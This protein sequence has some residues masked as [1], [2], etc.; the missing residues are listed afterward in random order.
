MA[1][2]VAVEAMAQ[3][4]HGVPAVDDGELAELEHLGVGGVAVAVVGGRQRAVAGQRH[5]GRPVRPRLGGFVSAAQD[6]GAGVE[7]QP[8]RRQAGALQGPGGDA[9]ED[10]MAL[11]EEGVEGPAEAVVVERV[12]GAVGEEGG[13]PGLVGPGG[14]VDEGGGLA[15]TT[16]LSAPPPRQVKATMGVLPVG[17]SGARLEKSRCGRAVQLYLTGAVN[18]P[19][20][21]RNGKNAAG[22]TRPSV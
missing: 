16:R 13:G 22:P 18:R 11:V 6:D 8:V 5:V 15:L 2:A 9:A 21:E 12:G 1:V 14:D 20:R 17:S 10:G 4:G 3:H 7:M 19:P